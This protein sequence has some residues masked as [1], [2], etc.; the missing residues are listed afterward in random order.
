MESRGR[1]NPRFSRKRCPRQRQP[2]PSCRISGRAQDS[3]GFIQARSE[4]GSGTCF[5]IYFPVVTA[6]QSFPLSFESAGR[7]PLPESATILLVD[8]ETALVQAIGEFLRE[9][10]FLVLD[11]FSS[12][13][14]LDL[15]K[16]Y[17]GRIDV[18]VT[19]VVMPGLRWPDL[20]TLIA[21]FQPEI[22]V[23]DDSGYAEGLPDMK[24]PPGELFLQKP[25]AFARCSKACS[26]SRPAT[27]LSSVCSRCSGT[28]AAS[29]T[30]ALPQ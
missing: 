29:L 28:G 10:G 15:A 24:L 20:R 6:S 2:H 21:E 13:E 22:Q 25:F 12:Q 8:D 3:L 30:F 19:D 26:S 27:D 7:S 17:P 23:L 11:V 16:E 1:K 18:L 9:S 5:E 14:A 4:P